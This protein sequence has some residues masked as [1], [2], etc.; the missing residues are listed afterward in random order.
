MDFFDMTGTK[1]SPEEIALAALKAAKREEG[2][3]IS[4]LIENF[5]T[6][7]GSINIFSFMALLK[8]PIEEG[9]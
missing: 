1:L 3:R 2:K 7:Q 6:E 9:K 4:K 8:K 5:I